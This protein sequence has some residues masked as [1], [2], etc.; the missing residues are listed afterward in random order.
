MQPHT[1]VVN[2]MRLTQVDLNISPLS[3]KD[4]NRTKPN[5]LKKAKNFSHR[6]V[7]ART[8]FTPTKASPPNLSKTQKL[9]RNLLPPVLTKTITMRTS[10][11]SLLRRVMLRF[12][13]SLKIRQESSIISRKVSSKKKLKLWLQLEELMGSSYL[14]M[15]M[16]KSHRL[17]LSQ[18]K[19]KL[20]PGR[21]K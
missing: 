11:T 9:P 8:T 10:S 1:N 20:S 4:F 2:L 15:K 13:H 7:R 21:V 5:T 16:I 12:Q 19:V 3:I 6:K 18:E 14:M 17:Q